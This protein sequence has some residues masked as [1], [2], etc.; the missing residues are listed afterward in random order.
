MTVVIE[1]AYILCALPC[2]CTSS[3]E[4][5]QMVLHR[6]TFLWHFM[7]L[8]SEA[9]LVYGYCD[10][11]HYTVYGGMISTHISRKVYVQE[12]VTHYMIC[13]KLQPKHFHRCTHQL[14]RKAGS[15]VFLK[16]LLTIL[17][18]WSTALPLVDLQ[19]FHLKD[20]KGSMGSDFIMAEKLRSLNTTC[21]V[22]CKVHQEIT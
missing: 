11:V 19:T 9:Y 5:H 6:H 22:R 2:V 7:P 16:M 15:A 3:K 17:N 20:K 12:D 8:S 10:T 21:T 18:L 1:R 13:T 4:D 14:P